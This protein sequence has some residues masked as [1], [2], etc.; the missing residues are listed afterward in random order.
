MFWES[1]LVV[2]LRDF[3]ILTESFANRPCLVGMSHDQMIL[4]REDGGWSRWRRGLREG[5][6]TER[7]EGME[8]M[9]G[10]EELEEMEEVEEEKLLAS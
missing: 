3:V 10:I 1:V 6:R 7:M 9:E 8:E 5:R 4:D 2:H